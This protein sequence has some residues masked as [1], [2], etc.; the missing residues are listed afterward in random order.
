MRAFAGQHI[1]DAWYA[2]LD[3]EAAVGEFRSQLKARG[4]KRTEKMMAKAHTQDSMRALSKLT[5]VA[6][7]QRWIISDLFGVNERHEGRCQSVVQVAGLWRSH[8]AGNGG[9]GCRTWLLRQLRPVKGR[10]LAVG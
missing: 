5:S 9:Q 2:H 7:G 10:L 8:Q 4:V 1:M 6:G 3:V